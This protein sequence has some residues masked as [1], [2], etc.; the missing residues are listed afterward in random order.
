ALGPKMRH[1]LKAASRVAFGLAAPGPRSARCPRNRYSITSSA[2]AR[3]VGGT[4]RPSARAVCMLITN[5]N[6]VGCERVHLNWFRR[7]DHQD[8]PLRF[9][10]RACRLVLPSAK[11]DAA[12]KQLQI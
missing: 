3:S 10:C 12:N 7:N 9:Y 1:G 5:L 4:S 2:R 6:L 11:S 8:K